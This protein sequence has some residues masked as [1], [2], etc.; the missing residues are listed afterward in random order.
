[1]ET[2]VDPLLHRRVVGRFATGVTVI[3]TVLPDGSKHAMTAN[4]FTSVSLD[5]VLVLFC[6]DHSTR[7][8]DAVLRTGT[9]AVSVLAAEH[10]G[11]SRRFAVK[12]RD[13]DTQFD[14]VDH[15]PGPVTGAPVLTGALAALECSV[16]ST[17]EAGDH[18]VVVGRVLGLSEPAPDAE[19]LL[20][21]GGRYRS[22]A[23]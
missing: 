20:Y 22:L 6:A 14:G 15:A 2:A 13:L 4:S 3:T 1:M 8:H 17:T 18:T 7:F 23:D 12:G 9:F 16:E 19:P 5:P 10:E 11:A 21:F